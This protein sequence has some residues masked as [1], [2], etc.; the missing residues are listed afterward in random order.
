MQAL[1]ALSDSFVVDGRR[2]L[3]VSPDSPMRGYP[4][5]PTFSDFPIVFSFF[6]LLE[7]KDFLAASLKVF[8]NLLG[9]FTPIAWFAD[10]V[11]SCGYSVVRQCLSA[12]VN[13]YHY[14]CCS[15]VAIRCR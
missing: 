13:T 9:D 2:I 6:L 15:V 14:F 8:S 4:K 3:T 1:L 12:V 5:G 7:L 11:D 10:A